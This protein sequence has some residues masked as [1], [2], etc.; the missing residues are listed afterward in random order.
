[1]QSPF[2]AL[3]IALLLGWLAVLARET[4]ADDPPVDRMK[5][6]HC[7][8]DEGKACWHY[9]R[10]PLRPPEDPCRCGLCSV[11]GDCSSKEKPHG[12]SAE[13]MSSQKLPCFWKRHAGS[14]GITCSACVLDQECDSCNGVAGLPNA[15][16][17]NQVKKQLQ[18]E[19][20]N[21]KKRMMV[22][23]SE[24]FYLA[25][26]IPR[27]KL[28]TQGGAPRVADQ[29]EIVHLFLQRAEQA[30][31]DFTSVWGSMGS[32]GHTG[33]FL[34]DKK[35]KMESW[36][37]AYFGNPKTNMLYGAGSG[38]VAGGF[39]VNGFATS[40]DEYGNDRDLHAYVRHMCGHLLYSMWHRVNPDVRRTPKWAF[41]GAADWLCKLDPLFV[42]WTVFCFDEG[43]GSQASGK[44]WESKARA[45]AAGRRDPI[46]K[47]FSIASESHMTADDHI[48]SWSYMDVML[49]EDRER[50]LTTLAAIRDGKDP[51]P[52]FQEGLSM[53]PDEFD[54]R[55]AD[56][57]LGKRK[58]MLDVPKDAKVPEGEGPNA[59]ARRRITQE[60]DLQVL[61]A[62]IRGLDHVNDVKT[63]ELVLSR[64]GFD[65]DLIRET[66]V[67]LLEKTT[68]PEVIEWM[69]ST[70][71][72]S[73]DAMTRAHVARV[74]GTLKY[75]PARQALEAALDDPHWLV[76]A[77]AAQALAMLAD[78]ASAAALVAKIED[79]NP[80]A[81]IAKADAMATYGMATSAATVPVTKRLT[82]SD[83]QVRLTACRTL[84]KMGDKDA[85]EPL[86]DRLD[87]EGGRLKKEIH[88]ALQAVS[89]E[90]F[91][92]NPQTWRTWWKKQKPQGIPPELPPVNP[93]DARYAKP[94]PIRPE[95]P[96]YYGK[97]IFSQ[98][99]LFVIDLSLSMNT[100]I[101][102]PEEAQKRL[103]TLASGQRIAVAKEAARSAIA[104]LDDR[105][106]FNVVF[107]ST[108]VNPWQKG[109]VVAGGMKEAALSAIQA[110]ALEDET[111]IFGALRAAVGLHERSTLTA[112]LDPI[113]DTIYFMTDGTPTRGEITDTET[114]LSWMRDVNRFAKVELNVIAMG[115]MGVDLDF[116]RKLAEENHGEFTH[117]P[118]SDA[119]GSSPAPAMK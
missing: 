91:G 22:A 12:W 1:M 115:N 2:R 83:W 39:C 89:H 51:A 84:A 119:G 60:Q 25:T 108:K 85:V 106:R 87:G 64:L 98:S 105:A 95:D 69:R 42:D 78:P 32:G 34:A 6:G 110:A 62:L 38:R 109:L 55:W 43:Q 77:N 47:L 7:G 63:A 103:G 104:K 41:A 24:H 111:N 44:D 79:A 10:S 5:P 112:E 101:K 18:I 13:C 3:S 14:W 93:D 99:L 30:Y 92:E 70:A 46:E 35:G 19:G 21:P 117:V 17:Y 71:L 116:L 53:S 66:V 80:K 81:W 26:D 9:L 74:L 67:M 50:W 58:T 4:G 100:F 90:N 23:W 102:V 88:A 97:R 28:L 27:L 86:I 68:V 56:R 82:A 107:F 20:D 65:S 40:A 8:C 113:P 96:T 45:I 94:K 57:M 118:D 75:L 49:R 16:A 54:K 29:H 52:A 73:P 59:T 72:T 37:G 15:D 31:D 48:R 33:I 11:K 114:I 61:A 76:R 36:Q